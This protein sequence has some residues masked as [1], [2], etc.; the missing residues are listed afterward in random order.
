MRGDALYRQVAALHAANIDQGFLSVLGQPFLALV[1]RA[2]DEAPDSVL[3]VEEH[4][5]QVL[6]FVAGGT[7]MGAIYFR[8]LRRP[9]ALA[10]TLGPSLLRPARLLRIAEILLYGV[11]RRSRPGRQR[12]PAA[13]LLS[14]AV[15]PQA[16]GGGVADALYRRLAED[17]HSRGIT[18]FRIVVGDRL[19]PAHRFY[20]RMGAVAIGPIEV[21]A[22]ERSTLYV[23]EI[24]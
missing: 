24:P 12:L 17:L 15:A 3:I 8:L 16:R 4:G 1:Y 10:R 18:A 5:D 11:R 14:I 7:G 9:V 6:G 21:H 22:G 20:R 23:Q 2:I 13:E 19:S